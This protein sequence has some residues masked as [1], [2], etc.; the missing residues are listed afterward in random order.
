MQE[1]RPTPREVM[2]QRS[3]AARRVRGQRP[4][5]ELLEPR[6]LLSGARPGD[7]DGDFL[8]TRHDARTLATALHAG[9]LGRIPLVPGDLDGDGRITARDWRLIRRELRA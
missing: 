1:L 4:G 5:F 3:S 8:V 6:Q 2:P 7:I 9:Q